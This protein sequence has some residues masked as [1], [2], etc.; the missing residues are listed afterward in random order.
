MTARRRKPYGFALFAVLGVVGLAALGTWQLVR[1]S[2]KEA[3]IANRLAMLARPPLDLA[4]LKNVPADIAYRRVVVRG[5][6]LHDRELRVGPRS[7]DGQPGWQVITPL[8]RAD[9]GGIV[10]VD[11]GWVPDSRKDPKTR[12]EGQVKGPVTLT[13]FVRRVT[14][15]GA[16]VPDNDPARGDWYWVD[17]AAMAAQLGLSGVAPYWIVASSA[18]GRRGGPV[19]ADAPAM[20]P[21][22]HLGYAITWFGLAASLCVLAAVFWRRVT[23]GK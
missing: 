1:L 18:S 19:G 22:N 6:F 16:F 3:L 2:E 14:P 20:P 7:H 17:P 11:R 12:P 23:T 21:N 10:L 9:G 5:I 8:R 4:R 13:G 15:H